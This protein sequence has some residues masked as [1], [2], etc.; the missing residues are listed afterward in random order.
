[1][2]ILKYHKGGV[3]VSTLVVASIVISALV[4][5]VV[6]SIQGKFVAKLYVQADIN[7]VHNQVSEQYWH[8]ANSQNKYI[9]ISTVQVGVLN[10]S[11]PLV[12]RVK[13]LSI[14]IPFNLTHI[15]VLSSGADGNVTLKEFA[16]TSQLTNSKGLAV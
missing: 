10:L 14:H 12:A 16:D 2:N 4:I 8:C 15:T 6:A 13:Y 3:I 1:V 9:Y 5:G 7:V 11:V